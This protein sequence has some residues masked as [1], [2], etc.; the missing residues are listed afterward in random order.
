MIKIPNL[1]EQLLESSKHQFRSGPCINFASQTSHAE[2]AEQQK[3]IQSLEDSYQKLIDEESS[4]LLKFENL[5]LQLDAM[6][7][8]R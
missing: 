4:L 5:S 2:I 3:E 6:E 1:K 8:F 7:T